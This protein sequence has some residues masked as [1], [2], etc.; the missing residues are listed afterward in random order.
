[1]LLLAPCGRSA[2]IIL[3]INKKICLASFLQKDNSF[4]ARACEIDDQRHAKTE[5]DN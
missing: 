5:E 1:M 3:L 2:A 4:D